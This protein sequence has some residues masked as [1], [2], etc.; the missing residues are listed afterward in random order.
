L[1]L[2]RWCVQIMPITP[3]HFGPGAALHSAAPKHLSFLAF[4]TANVL[5]DVEPLINM[6]AHR[7]PVHGFLHTYLGAT[8]PLVA[9]VALFLAGC[10]LSSRIALLNILGWQQ[11]TIWPVIVGA[12]AGAYSHVA[13][14]SIMHSDMEPLAPFSASNGLL[15]IISLANLHLIC[16]ACAVL[17]ILVI[18]VRAMVS[19]E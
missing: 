5:I 7:Y 3:F 13:L 1:R 15:G 2:T 14:G 10:W 12:A 8:I 9:T 17:G 18:G 4:C 11:L 19:K 16:V 6:L